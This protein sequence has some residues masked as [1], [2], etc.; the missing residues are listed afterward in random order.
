MTYNRINEGVFSDDECNEIIKLIDQNPHNNG[1]GIRYFLRDNP[2]VLELIFESIKFKEIVHKY[3]TVPVVIKSI[4]FD[5][6]AKLNWSVNW[7]QDITINLKSKIKD[8]RFKNWRILEDRVVVQPNLELLNSILTFRI[9]LDKTDENNG[10]LSVVNDS[11]ESGVL[12][13]SEEYLN[14]VRSRIDI[15]EIERGGVM[16]M[17]PLTVHSSRRSKLD[18]SR[19]RVIHLEITELSEAKNLPFVELFEII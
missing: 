13:V 18:V 19:R 7:H 3:F 4:Y 10:A 16:M 17:S 15:A 5:K 11:E 12:R 9:H 14:L 8:D 2:E 1:F 6:P